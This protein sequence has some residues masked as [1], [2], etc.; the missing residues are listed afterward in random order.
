MTR[1]LHHHSLKVSDAEQSLEFYVNRL[2]MLIVGHTEA[3]GD[4]PDRYYLSFGGTDDTWLELIADRNPSHIGYEHDEGD[5]YWKTN[6]TVP[7]LDIAR[8]RLYFNGIQVS[9]PA[10]FGDIG[11]MCHLND[12]D[13]YIIELL[14]HTHGRNAQPIEA[15]PD[16]RLGSQPTLAHV[17]LRCRNPAISIP[18]YR[19]LLGMRLL[20]RQHIDQ[21]GF[22]LYFLAFTD[23]TP[24]SGDINSVE[25]REWLWQR[26]YSMVELQHVNGT[27]G[28]GFSYRT[29]EDGPYGFRGITIHAADRPELFRKAKGFSFTIETPENGLL[30]AGEPLIFRDPDGTQI[31]VIDEI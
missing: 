2:G 10:Q 23:E 3:T 16:I 15:D 28:T 20:S 26:P 30:Q 24:P 31:R 9:E 14:Q 27:E 7:D 6:I 22:T 19:D 8:E 29:D 11:Y 13:G 21:R 12:P 18:F 1:R 17:T 5:L 4:E 25:D